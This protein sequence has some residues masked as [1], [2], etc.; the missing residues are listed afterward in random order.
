ML[1]AVDGQQSWIRHIQAPRHS[2]RGLSFWSPLHCMTLVQA[3]ATLRGIVERCAP[4]RGS[5][6]TSSRTRV[7][8]VSYV[9]S[10]TLTAKA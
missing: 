4:N 9:P 5:G 1:L 8:I 6:E 10:P 7:G 3:T 2:G